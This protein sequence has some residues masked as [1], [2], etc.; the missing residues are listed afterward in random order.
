MILLEWVINRLRE[1]KFK[2]KKKDGRKTPKG[3][4]GQKRRRVE[5]VEG[6]GKVKK[7]KREAARIKNK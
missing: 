6:K 1:K 4:K 3:Q 2:F 7:G 5:G